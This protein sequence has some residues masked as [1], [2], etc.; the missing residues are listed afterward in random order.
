L[1]LWNSNPALTK[2]CSLKSALGHGVSS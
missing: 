1:N 2:C